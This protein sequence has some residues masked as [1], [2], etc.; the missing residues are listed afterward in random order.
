M[1]I[2]RG[3]SWGESRPLPADGIVVASDAEARA[4]VEAAWQ[5]GERLPTLGLLGGDL[6][7]T[8][9]GPLDEA[10]LRSSAAMTFSVDLGIAEFDGERHCFVAHGVARRWWW[11]GRAVAAMNAQWLGSWDLGPRSHPNDG[12]LDVTDGNPPMGERL[13]MRRRAHTGTHLPHPDLATSRVASLDLTFDRP[14]D[15]W[16][17]GT[18][19]GRSS[20]LHLAVEP[21][22]LLVVI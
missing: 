2:R 12:L 18:R 11:L 19:V 16:L 8:L 13:E 6:C 3:E 7:R 22:A 1:T 10:H 15:I 5:A 20:I 14:L 17:D 4:V 9:G 21:D